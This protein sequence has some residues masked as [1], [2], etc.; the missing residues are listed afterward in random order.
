MIEMSAQSLLRVSEIRIKN[1]RSFYGER[2]P[3]E[4][5]TDVDKPVTVI[6]GTS[7][8]GKTTLLN[9]IHWCIYNKEGKIK[10]KKTSSEG[11]IHSAVIESLKPGEEANMFVEITIEN[12]NHMVVNEIKRE[13]KITKSSM[14]GEDS[15]DEKL[16]AKV[17]PGITAEVSAGFT[18]K[19]PDTDEPRHVSDEDN[20]NER[21]EQIFPAALSSYILFDAELLRKFEEANESSVIQDGIETITGLP[22]IEKAADKLNKIGKKITKD[23][24]GESIKFQNLMKHVER[25][26]KGIKKIEGENEVYGSKILELAKDEEDKVKFLLDNDD[27]NVAK[28]Q[29]RENE[30]SGQVKG[31]TVTIGKIRKE[32][33]NTIFDNLIDC[34]LHDAL[35]ISQKKLE[36][37]RN[38]GL[39][40]SRFTKEALQSLLDDTLCV[41]GRGLKE[42]HVHEKKAITENM[43]KVYE[44]A[45]ASEMG[46]ISDD[47]DQ[48][49]SKTGS[50]DT[51]KLYEEYEKLKDDL[52]E[53]RS[54]RTSLKSTLD[55]M[56]SNIDPKLQD[57]VS[58]TRRELT[59][60]RSE[61]DKIKAKMV[62]NKQKLDIYIP[63]LKEKD[64]EY[65]KMTKSVIKDDQNGHKIN[66]SM[67]GESIFKQTS[68]SLEKFFKTNVEAATQEYFLNTAPEKEEFSG[69]KINDETYAISA[70]RKGNKEKEPSQGQAHCL[71]LSYIA[72][73]RKVTSKNYFMMI[74]SPFHNISQESKLQV[75]VELPTKM[76]ATQVTFFCTD[77]EYRAEIPGDEFDK[78][79]KASAKQVLR[80][81]N[82]I[83]MQYNLQTEMFE[84]NGE[85]YRNTKIDK[86]TI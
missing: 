23:N 25:L 3:I 86:V 84:L 85:T 81:N 72:G 70:V 46:R 41:C 28:E 75:C 57:K 62:Q 26:E 80:D 64:R 49:V 53:A 17:P 40:P 74:D 19:D 27:E 30:I 65:Q 31:L 51:E 47:I 66:L 43:N 20:V 2:E 22:I 52:A 39:V 6:H 35:I 45:I 8:R 4:L 7:G 42:E 77:T 56:R 16:K 61:I 36:K 63:E 44:A 5:S 68:E 55:K 38:K 12:E 60:L 78:E 1:F 73:V 37:W 82:L 32:M 13:I 9:A 18:Y 67:F 10:Q 15:W 29:E 50:E 76:D 69:V 24:V 71:G 59:K 11:L 34:Y 83:G 14:S 21:I 58:Q 54:K 79:A 33:S 48:I